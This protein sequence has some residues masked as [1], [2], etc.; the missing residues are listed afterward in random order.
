MSLVDQI[1]AE[2]RA[3]TPNVPL[4]HNG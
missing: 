2:I 4:M 3:E 1:A